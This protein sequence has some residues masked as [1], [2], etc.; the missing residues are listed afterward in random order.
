MSLDSQRL[1]NVAD[2]ATLGLGL[3]SGPWLHCVTVAVIIRIRLL[4]ERNVT[5][6]VRFE[7]LHLV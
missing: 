2:A 1:R 3:E 4:L 7:L 6:W 5:V